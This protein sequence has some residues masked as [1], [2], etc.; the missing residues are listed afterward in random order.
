MLNVADP[1]GAQRVHAREPWDPCD[2]QSSVVR[3]AVFCLAS[4]LVGCGASAELTDRP[5]TNPSA[6]S[7]AANGASTTARTQT[8]GSRPGATDGVATL[9]LSVS[10]QSF[11]DDP[12][13]I[14]VRIDGDVVVDD[15]FFVGSQHNW[16]TFDLAMTP[17]EHLVSLTSDTNVESETTL[18]VR[19]DGHRWAVAAYWCQPSARTDT[20]ASVTGEFSFVVDDEPIATA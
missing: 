10:N 5:P 19:S 6:E 1:D 18:A 13:R 17:G 20:A 14:T 11:A 3:A 12:V 9:T 15:D 2:R 8:T 7:A 16:R 4:L